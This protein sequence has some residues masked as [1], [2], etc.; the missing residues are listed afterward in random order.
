MVYNYLVP[1]V[2]VTARSRPLRVDEEGVGTGLFGVSKAIRD[3]FTE[4]FYKAACFEVRVRNDRRNRPEIRT[5]FGRVESSQVGEEEWSRLF[6]PTHL[7][8]IRAISLNVMMGVH[9]PGFPENTPTI[10]AYAARI[11]TDYEDF[12]AAV[13]RMATRIPRSLQEVRVVV[14]IFIRDPTVEVGALHYAGPG[15]WL[16]E[17]EVLS[18]E[19]R[20]YCRH[21][22]DALRGLLR[23]HPDVQIECL[24]E[25]PKFPY[26]DDY[27]DTDSESCV[28]DPETEDGWI[29]Y[30]CDLL[31]EHD[32]EEGSEED[33][34]RRQMVEFVDSCRQEMMGQ[35]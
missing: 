16:E 22:L 17:N 10:E 32:E 12:S 27:P 20:L 30:E 3:E 4:A 31:E 19:A 9:R 34:S 21:F 14:D 15:N 29:L 8:R 28:S 23:A 11:L 35:S 25:G 5:C 24:R 26:R 6:P 13:R 7:D 33:I 2:V 1:N 18:Q